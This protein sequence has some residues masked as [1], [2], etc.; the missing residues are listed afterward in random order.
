MVVA[1][2]E[3]SRILAEVLTAEGHQVWTALDARNAYRSLLSR[4]PDLV[5]IDVRLPDS[6]GIEVLRTLRECPGG[7]EVAAILV[8]EDPL[9]TRFSARDLRPDRVLGKPLDMLD[10]AEILRDIAVERPGLVRTTLPPDPPEVDVPAP[11]A[12]VA[13]TLAE[14]MATFPPTRIPTPQAPPGVTTARRAAPDAWELLGVPRD[15]TA[16]DI[17]E[18]SERLIHVYSESALSERSLDA[19]SRASSM[20]AR[21]RA[22]KR[23]LLGSDAS[24]N[25]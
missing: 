23:S 3:L 5:V 2:A 12:R 8:S 22:A 6:S 13:S 18:A 7:R 1:S 4:L 19:R 20:V 10:L 17:Q 14:T 24:E 15:A 21:V 16:E 9:T 25:G 11:A